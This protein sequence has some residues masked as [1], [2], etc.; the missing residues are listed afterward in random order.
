MSVPQARLCSCSTADLSRH[1]DGGLSSSKNLIFSFKKTENIGIRSVAFFKL[2]NHVLMCCIFLHNHICSFFLRFNT[3]DLNE[4]KIIWK[5]L[6]GM[7]RTYEDLYLT[8]QVFLVE[9]L[10]HVQFGQL[11]AAHNV[12][13]KL[14]REALEQ[15]CK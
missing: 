13:Q 2:S 10:E 1:R 7:L 6:A 8:D 14:T 12:V 4:R 15:Q 3:P 9:A 5:Q 11:T